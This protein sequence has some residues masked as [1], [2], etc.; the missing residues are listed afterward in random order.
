MAPKKPLFL[1]RSRSRYPQLLKAASNVFVAEGQTLDGP[2]DLTGLT[3]KTT[4]KSACTHTDVRQ[5][6]PLVTDPG[7]KLLTTPAP[8]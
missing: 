3:G 2:E 1:C 5:V 7:S 8:A 4:F 6:L